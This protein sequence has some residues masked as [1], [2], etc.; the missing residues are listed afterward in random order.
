MLATAPLL[1][2]QTIRIELRDSIGALPVIGALVTASDSASTA[3]VDGLTNERGVVTLR[4]PTSGLWTIGIR[5]IGLTPRRVPAI[6]VAPGA[7]ITMP[8]TV[9]SMRQILARVRVSADAG[10]CGR[11]PEGEDRTAMLWEQI[12]LALRASTLSRDGAGAA[13]RGLRV[14]ER[15]RE[16]TPDLKEISSELRKSG[17]FMGR[18]YSAADPDSLATLGYV[19]A[20]GSDDFSYFAP[21]E[22]VLLSDAF[23]RTH[24]FDTPKKDRDPAL[25]ELHF[26]PLRGRTV[27]DV[28]GTA[29]V[30]TLSGEL[31][32]LEFRF[33][34][35]RSVI[36]VNS[37]H[38]GGD[39]MLRRLPDG[40]WIVSQWVIRMPRYSRRNR[41]GTFVLSGYREIGGAVK[42]VD[43]VSP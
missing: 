18:P 25:A 35:S 1:R 4:L 3:R 29:F 27:A 10:F 12:T 30:D 14:E 22:V 20:E 16:L 42:P 21:D 15:V 19:R 28:Q 38:A 31:R 36:P 32:R 17:L 26:R 2:A 40:Q 7:V 6:R 8:L 11:A 24:C 34:A 5:R 39:V 23:L 9:T 41:F 33:V 37:P 13:R 43:D